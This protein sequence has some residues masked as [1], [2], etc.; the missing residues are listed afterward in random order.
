MSEG[1]KRTLHD[2]R[3]R[4]TESSLK[5][6]FG[7]VGRK[8]KPNGER[9][10]KE[11]AGYLD[12][13]GALCAWITQAKNLLAAGMIVNSD[14]RS[15]IET[16]LAQ[17]EGKPWRNFHNIA[18]RRAA[19]LLMLGD[20]DGAIAVLKPFPSYLVK[21]DGQDHRGDVL[22][23]MWLASLYLQK[24]RLP[25]AET[26]Y[27]QVV[28]FDP[29]HVVAWN[30]LGSLHAQKGQPVEAEACLCEAFA[31]DPKNAVTRNSLGSLY[32]QKGQLDEAEA[33]FRETLGLYPGNVVTLNSLGSLCVQKGRQAEAEALFRKT[34]DLSPKNIVARNSLGHLYAQTGR[35]ADAETLFLSVLDQEPR[36]AFT[37]GLLGALYMKV[38]RLEEAEALFLR[39]KHLDHGNMMIR[40]A[41]GNLL[42]RKKNFRYA[43]RMFHEILE[44]DP[45]NRVVWGSLANLRMKQGRYKDARACLEKALVGPQKET[46]TAL[47]LQAKLAFLTGNLAQ[48]QT[49]TQPVFSA[50]FHP[51]NKGVIIL[52]LAALPENSPVA[53]TYLKGIVEAG[54]PALAAEL[55]EMVQKY[56]AEKAQF[57]DGP[58]VGQGEGISSHPRW[59][60]MD[61]A[62][63]HFPVDRGVEGDWGPEEG[64]DPSGRG[65][66]RVSHPVP[67][68]FCLPA[69]RTL[70]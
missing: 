67:A 50:A 46:R 23:V 37:L 14:Q 7:G 64:D 54:D 20:L 60:K 18:T 49:L 29:E 9:R 1:K 70:G 2:F 57:D 52:H 19:L 5:H 68:G 47:Y 44:E 63:S 48:C 4:G 39:A 34:L 28:E 32:A 33:L 58:L 11:A 31:L 21:G 8:P 13:Q 16:H 55:R 22:A 62:M 10:L 6:T 40:H 59:R 65:D 61:V 42:V 43:E 53:K 17:A 24:G 56:R 35:T 26:L 66:G 3:R 30:S 51:R 36:N 15:E 41:L 25:E 27:R 69:G 12:I 38:E 45:E